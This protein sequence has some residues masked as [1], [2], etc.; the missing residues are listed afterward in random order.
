VE[1]ETRYAKTVDG[2]HI[3][4]QIRGDGPIDLVYILGFAS[5]FEIELEERRTRAFFDRLSS[6]TRL[7]LFDKRGTGLSDRHQTPDLDMRADDLRAVLDAVGSDQAVLFG[8]SEGGALAAFFASTHP[9]R[10]SALVLY[11]SAARYAWAPDYPIGMRQ[12]EFDRSHDE[13]ARSWGTIEHA[14]AWVEDESPSVAGDAELIR[15]WAR[16]ERFGASPAAALAFDDVWYA[17]D[18]RG[19]L[20]SVQAPTLVLCRP[21]AHWDEHSRFLGGHIPGAQLVELPG[22]DYTLVLGDIDAPLA[23]IEAFLGSISA[24]QAEID[25]ALATVL[26]T[27]IVGSTERSS[28][29]RAEEWRKLLERHHEVVRAML[30]RYRGAEIDTAGDGFFATFD[31]PARAVRCAQA[32]VDAVRPLGIEIRAGV[33]TGEVDTIDGK[34]GGLAVSIGARV[35]AAAEASEVLV[36]STVKDLVAGSGLAFEDRGEYELKGV[37]DRWRLYR[38]LPAEAQTS[39][40]TSAG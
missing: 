36:S 34:V 4:Y 14:R 24:E 28:S 19:I 40:E 37:P 18:V 20:G 23:T 26:F 15:M 13:I 33:H 12:D 38:A 11:G 35:G 16:T 29:M 8:H 17:T 21:A 1:P 22:S 27:D 9:E 2:V 39:A 30:G 6:F 32:I 31:G 25:R 7:I 5:C 10:V 3:A